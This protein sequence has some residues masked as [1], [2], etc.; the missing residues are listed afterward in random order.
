MEEG[1]MTQEDVAKQL[2]DFD[3]PS[4]QCNVIWIHGVEFTRDNSGLLQVTDKVE[5]NAS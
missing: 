2:L 4:E 1:I 3:P 5:L